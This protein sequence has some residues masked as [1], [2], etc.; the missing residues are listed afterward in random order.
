VKSFFDWVERFLGKL[1]FSLKFS[2]LAAGVTLSSLAL[3]LLASYKVGAQAAFARKELSGLDGI[4]RVFE[5]SAT[6]QDSLID[7]GGDRAAR[8]AKIKSQLEDLRKWA[9]TA[10]GS[11]KATEAAIEKLDS[12]S[13]DAMTVA[14]AD[15]LS[16]ISDDANLTLDP[17]LDSYYLVDS[18]TQ[19]MLP[20]F[21]AAARS[22]APANVQGVV[23]AEALTAALNSNLAKIR[24]ANNAIGNVLADSI[25]KSLAAVPRATNSTIS[26]ADRITALAAV[27]EVGTV[28]LQQL[29]GILQGR[30]DELNT[31]LRLVIAAAIAGLLFGAIFLIG[32]YRG[33]QRNL[34]L[35]VMAAESM[36][37]GDLSIR[38]TSTA[39]DEAGRVLA[40]FQGVVDLLNDF[41]E[42]QKEVA[43]QHAQGWIE[44]SIPADRFP[45]VFGKIAAD[46]NDLVHSHIRTKMRL[47]ELIR[48]YAD[49]DLTEDMDRL[50]GMEAKITDS[51]DTAKRNLRGISHEIRTLVEAA[52]SGDLTVR[53]DSARYQ[54]EFRDMVIG[55]NRLM[56]INTQGIQDVMVVLAALARGDLTQKME[57]DFHGMFAQLRDD[58]NTTVEQ[59]TNIVDQIKEASDQITSGSREIAEGNS[60][61]ADRT[62]QQA[63]AL[64]ETATSMEEL[65]STVRQNAEN[66][67]QANQLAIGAADV[68]SKGGRVVGEVVTTMASINESSKKIVDIIA[69]IDG[70]AF[71]TNILALNAAVEA[72]R[73]GEQGR[74]FAVVAAEV[75][76]L[77]QRSAGA[78]KEIKALIS[79]SVDRVETGT[80]LV[81]QAGRTMDEI[82]T[83]VKRVTDIMSEIS[84]A[85]QEQ[86]HGIEQVTQTITQMDEVTQQNAALVEEASTS[87]RAM[88]DQ[89]GGLAQSVSI[90]TLHPQGQR[91]DKGRGVDTDRAMPLAMAS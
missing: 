59:L 13:P 75:R 72:A 18:L 29:R 62:K 9:N 64:K 86:S 8:D 30:L 85:S 57:G 89:A 77:A 19:R 53:G 91:A 66:A 48:K 20:Y 43:R 84:A 90:F 67:K 10:N 70:I 26:V 35:A 11:G 22:E 16:A 68:A 58:A 6:A 23:A 51:M 88:D 63:M 47:A 55:L 2:V 24:G 79:D 37:K 33:M 46:K 36:Q 78:A 4:Q 28:H 69:V 49:G 83:S 81:E 7:T 61:L 42:A 25:S 31:Q 71:Q 56:E 74:G 44:Y 82:V 40:A 27:R 17:V 1:S 45:G 21:N 87:A 14:L 32:F 41:I 5:L 15:L 80:Q 50:P 76:S 34:R 65:T 54:Y 3:V 12:S 52:A 39:T 38:I 73:A 60:N